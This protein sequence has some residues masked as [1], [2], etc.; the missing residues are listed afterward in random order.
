MND[1]E[2]QRRARL[3]LKQL[4]GDAPKDLCWDETHHLQGHV[5]IGSRELVVIAPRDERHEPVVLTAEDWDEIR[6]A[7]GEQA[8]ELVRQR[9]IHD[10][11]QL[12]AAVIRPSSQRAHT[13]SSD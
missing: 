13:S 11:D 8:G 5:H 6:H 10:H 7:P 2:G 12:T 3:F 1:D 4:L 9:A